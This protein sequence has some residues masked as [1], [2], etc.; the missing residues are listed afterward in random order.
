M[1]I[2]AKK[3]SEFRLPEHSG[4]YKQNVSASG[5]EVHTVWQIQ[6]QLFTINAK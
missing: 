3:I 6:S 5:K 2:H 4:F 1:A